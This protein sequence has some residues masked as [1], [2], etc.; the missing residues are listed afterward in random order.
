MYKIR[1]RTTY[2]YTEEGAMALELDV[3]LRHLF[4]ERGLLFGYIRSIVRDDHMAEDVLQEVS[5]LAMQKRK[6]I[7][8]LDALGRWL[9][10][11]ARLQ[12]LDAIRAAHRAPMLFDDA[13]LDLL[14]QRW[15]QQE[16]EARESDRLDALRRCIEELSD[17]GRRLL[18]LRYGQG[19]AGPRLGQR[20]GKPANTVSV[21]LSRVHSSLMKC[22]VRRMASSHD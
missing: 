17:Y 13:V 8:D 7:R 6:Q 18:E 21:A 14:D 9:R 20:L 16:R 12:S 5:I 15:E 22:V 4:A 2:G 10:S 1:N 3:I 11:A 19:L